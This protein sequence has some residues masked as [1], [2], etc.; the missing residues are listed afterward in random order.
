VQVDNEALID[1]IYATIAGVE[2]TFNFHNP[3][4][5]LSQY[6]RDR[7]MAT[8][9]EF[10]AL[11]SLAEDLRAQSGGAFSPYVKEALDLG[12]IAKGWAV[13][14]AIERALE[15]DPGAKGYVEAGGDIRFFGEAQTR[16]ALRVGSPPNVCLREIELSGA[17]MAVASSSPGMAQQYGESKTT[18]Q[19]GRWPEGSSVSVVASTCALADAL[20]KVVLFGKP[21]VWRKIDGQARVFVFDRNG[22]LQEGC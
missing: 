21:D 2:E 14:R 22:E 9:H 18:L 19:P 13:D 17:Q 11:L 5:E 10:R 3:N 1:A 15:L 12:G 20:T 6:D 8:S 7:S 16:V 4:S